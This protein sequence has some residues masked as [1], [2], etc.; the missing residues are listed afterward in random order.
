MTL[1]KKICDLCRHQGVNCG[2]V[3]INYMFFDYRYMY[4]LIF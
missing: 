1:T 3:V 4:Q 2:A